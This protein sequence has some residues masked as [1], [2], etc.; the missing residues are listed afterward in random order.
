MIYRASDIITEK[1]KLQ[2]G[3]PSGMVSTEWEIW[4]ELLEWHMLEWTMARGEAFPKPADVWVLRAFHLSPRSKRHHASPQGTLHSTKPQ[5]CI[6][7]S[8]R[9]SQAALPRRTQPDS[10]R[11]MHLG[12]RACVPHL[13]CHLSQARGLRQTTVAALLLHHVCHLSISS[14]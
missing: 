10:S 4:G 7:A 5:K 11:Q 14:R 3:T 13:F 12:Q 8:P 6:H 9:N 2:S 1:W